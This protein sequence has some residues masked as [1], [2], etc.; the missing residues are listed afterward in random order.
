MG[1]AEAEIP[2][3][4]ESYRSRFLVGRDR[5]SHA[6]GSVKE[7]ASQQHPE[8]PDL[9]IDGRSGHQLRKRTA[10]GNIWGVLLA[11]DLR[12][13]VRGRAGGLENTARL[14]CFNTDKPRAPAGLFKA[15]RWPEKG[16]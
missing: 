13:G 5:G 7:R 12:E 1:A 11:F 3:C 16:M 9:S 2:H 14:T 6:S 10:V 8:P 15:S 4:G